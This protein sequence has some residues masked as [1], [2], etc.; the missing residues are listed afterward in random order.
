MELVFVILAP[1]AKV[2]NDN[3]NELVLGALVSKSTIHMS[4]LFPHPFGMSS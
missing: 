3:A 2:V 4:V 1:K